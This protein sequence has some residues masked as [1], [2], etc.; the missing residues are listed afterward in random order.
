[1][2]GSGCYDHMPVGTT[3]ESYCISMAR[4]RHSIAECGALPPFMTKKIDRDWSI[5]RHSLAGT[6][7]IRVDA[8]PEVDD[9]PYW[10]RVWVVSGGYTV[11]G[12]DV[13]VRW[14]VLAATTITQSQ[15]GLEK[16]GV[17]Y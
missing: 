2:A 10:T 3:D 6:R 1:M 16:I 17:R 13:V 12:R 15:D 11:Q 5:K 14:K 9:G 8:K 4:V 7:P